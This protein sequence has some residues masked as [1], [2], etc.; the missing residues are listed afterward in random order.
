MVLP[1]IHT[2]FN[3]YV[4]AL[5]KISHVRLVTAIDINEETRQ[6]FT[7]A[8]TKRIKRDVAL[9]CSVD[10][11]IIDGA[12]IYIGDCVIDGSIRGKLSRLQQNLVA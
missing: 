1:E 5:D 6:K 9:E 4:A 7:T 10:P 8:L 2:V 11:S 3:T 12:I